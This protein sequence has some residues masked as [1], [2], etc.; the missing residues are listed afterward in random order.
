MKDYVGLKTQ[1]KILAL[2]GS[3]TYLLKIM[4]A[5]N[6]DPHRQDQESEYV[7]LG[8]GKIL[9]HHKREDL[10]PQEKQDQEVHSCK[11]HAI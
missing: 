6:T 1:P 8:A 7:R 11:H 9:R 4:V 3:G 5:R 10:Q 2:F